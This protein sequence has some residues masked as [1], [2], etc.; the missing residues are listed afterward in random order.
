MMISSKHTGKVTIEG[1]LP[2][3]ICK[4]AVGRNSNHYKFCRCW[5][6]KR[7][8]GIRGEL[9][10]DRKCTCQACANQKE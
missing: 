7:C 6:H 9:K 8:A 3:A 5:L 2:S 4:K 1:K 10:E